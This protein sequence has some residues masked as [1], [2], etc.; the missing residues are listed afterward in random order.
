LISAIANHSKAAQ[1]QSPLEMAKAATVAAR[2]AKLALSA[3]HR[4]TAIGYSGS[5][6][7]YLDRCV[8]GDPIALAAL[9]KVAFAVQ[10]EEVERRLSHAVQAQELRGQ[11]HKSGK[12]DPASFAPLIAIQVSKAA[13][14]DAT[15]AQLQA[16][17]MES[18]SKPDAAE[19]ARK[20]IAAA[21]DALNSAL[22]AL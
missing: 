16:G 11:L 5:R 14:T 21:M 9:G 19:A 4:S 2:A 15:P 10:A 7:P 17:F 13:F 3:L 12:T 1:N 8:T 6:T 22:A 20:A 18:Q